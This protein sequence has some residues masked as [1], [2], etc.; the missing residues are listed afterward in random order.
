MREGGDEDR[1]EDGET[2]M[3][4]IAFKFQLDLWNLIIKVDLTDEY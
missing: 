3:A 4:Y 1:D 2:D